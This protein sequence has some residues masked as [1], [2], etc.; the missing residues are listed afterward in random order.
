[1]FPEKE[2]LIYQDPA[3]ERFFDPLAVKRS[4]VLAGRGQLNAHFATYGKA[5]ADPV[6]KARAEEAI[7][8]AGRAAF[9]L[10]PID[11][12]TGEGVGDAKVIEAVTAFTRWLRGKDKAAQNGPNSAPCT[13]CPPVA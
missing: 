6:A 13:A 5:D 9:G 2:R 11:P 3:T 7:V 10:P 1:M 4:L 12:K 8:A